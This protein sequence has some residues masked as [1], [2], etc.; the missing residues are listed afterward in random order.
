L[1]TSYGITGSVTGKLLGA[2]FFENCKT[3]RNNIGEILKKQTNI[4]KICNRHKR[5]KLKNEA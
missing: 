4:Y 2:Q 1:K 3:K 5:H